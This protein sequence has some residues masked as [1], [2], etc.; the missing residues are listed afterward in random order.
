MIC[1]TMK[2]SPGFIFNLGHGIL[3]K[4]P[5]EHVEAVVDYVKQLK[6]FTPTIL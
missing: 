5:L 6:L 1:D 3:P 2:D 4:T